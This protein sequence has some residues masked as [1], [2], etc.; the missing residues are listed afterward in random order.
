MG[1]GRVVVVHLPWR[2]AAQEGDER[3]NDA[4][5]EEDGEENESE[6]RER[7]GNGSYNFKD[8]GIQVRKAD[9]RKTQERRKAEIILCCF[10]EGHEG[11]KTE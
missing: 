9:K 10:A 5:S 3:L 8:M 6:S 1:V 11:E 2:A 4:A 7:E